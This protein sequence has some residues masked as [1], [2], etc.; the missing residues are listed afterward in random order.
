LSATDP[1]SVALWIARS[2]PAKTTS[3]KI[4]FID[5]S[6]IEWISGTIARSFGQLDVPFYGALEESDFA[7]TSQLRIPPTATIIE[8]GR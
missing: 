8:R 4:R 3:L 7:E 1:C 5:S 6:T 2:A